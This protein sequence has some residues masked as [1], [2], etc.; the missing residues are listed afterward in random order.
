M[1]DLEDLKAEAMKRV[2]V[3]T[4]HMAP[5]AL[6][7]AAETLLATAAD[8]ATEED[9]FVYYYR[10]AQYLLKVSSHPGL[11]AGELATALEWTA[12]AA[13]ELEALKPRILAARGAVAAAAAAAPAD[14]S[15]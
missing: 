9:A 5:A 7:S 12:R 2:P 6:L 3:V 14:G 13:A 1:A 11:S 10:L 4:R 15:H 8:A